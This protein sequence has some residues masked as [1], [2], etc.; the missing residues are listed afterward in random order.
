MLRYS[1]G[2]SRETIAETFDKLLGYRPVRVEDRGAVRMIARIAN[3]AVNDAGLGRL[4]WQARR[5]AR[6]RV[7]NLAAHSQA[8][9]RRSSRRTRSVARP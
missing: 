5:R 9:A 7:W 8:S 4:L 6:S 2:P 1:Y 3:R